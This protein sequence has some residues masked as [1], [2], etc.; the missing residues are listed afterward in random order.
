[1]TTLTVLIV[2]AVVA[3]AAVLVGGVASMAH[4]GEFDRRHSHQFM[5]TRVG[6]QALA[7]LLLLAALVFALD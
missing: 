4:G 3:T 2:L 1:M 7:L 5:L 6:L